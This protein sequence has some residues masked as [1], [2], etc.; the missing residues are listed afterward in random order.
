[1]SKEITMTVTD[2][3]AEIV[4][5]RPQ[6]HNAVTPEMAALLQEAC[7]VADRDEAVRVVLIR[8]AG[9]RAFSSCSDLNSLAEYPSAWGFRN[10]VTHP[11]SATSRSR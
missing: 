5:N 9:E 2:F 7:A 4:L 3:G 8:G 1:M 10:R 6:K 11:P